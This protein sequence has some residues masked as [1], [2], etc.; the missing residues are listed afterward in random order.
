VQWLV[1]ATGREN[2]KGSAVEGATFLNTDSLTPVAEVLVARQFANVADRIPKL[3]AFLASDEIDRLP[4]PALLFADDHADAQRRYVEALAK[5]GE[6]DPLGSYA[7]FWL[8]EAPALDTAALAPLIEVL[9]ELDAHSDATKLA[10][11]C[12]VLAAHR[13]SAGAALERLL[14]LCHQPAKEHVRAALLATIASLGE[15]A[16]LPLAELL[17]NVEPQQAEQIIHYLAFYGE[18]AKPAVPL[19]LERAFIKP[20][21]QRESE[22]IAGYD[23]IAGQGVLARCDPDG[24]ATRA[25]LERWRKHPDERYR[26]AFETANEYLQNWP[27]Y[28]GKPPF[29]PWSGP[30]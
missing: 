30:F 7:A 5:C 25:V 23:G 24:K 8:S 16:I 22:L 15:K 21:H 4:R 13:G 18:A 2:W 26:R 29:R 3:L 27:A 9:P 28:S 17:S 1:E 12:R 11:I 14:A 6:D 19:L 20:V 10:A